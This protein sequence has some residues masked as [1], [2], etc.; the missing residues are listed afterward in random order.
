MSGFDFDRTTDRRHTGSVKWDSFEKGDDILPMWVADMD[1]ETAPAVKEA[2]M[3]RAATGIYGYT[4]IPM[5]EYSAAVGDWMERRHG[6]RPDPALTVI[7]T[8]VVPAISACIK[9]MTHPGDGVIVQTPV[10]N[11]FFS[12]IRNN[13]CRMVDAPLRKVDLRDMGLFTY[14]M[15]FN[16][17]ER[18]AADP[19][20]KVLL[21]CNPHN[22]AGRAWTRDELLKVAEICRRHEVTVVSDEIHCDLTMPGYEF[23]SYATLP[24]EFSSRAFVLASPS[25]AFNTAGLQIANIFAGNGRLRLAADRAVNDME[26][27]D[28]N[29][30]GVAGLIAAYTKGEEWLRELL[31]YLDGNYRALREFFRRELPGLSISRLEAT[32][33]VWVD[34]KPLGIESDRL[35]HLLL[36]EG[37][38]WL[39]SGVMYGADGFMR[40]N[41]ATQRARMMEGLRRFAGV[42]KDLI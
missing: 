3:A 11:C 16:A 4:H 24:E 27:C 32:Y 12:S 35:E 36:T 21:L 33:L 25:K 9:A 30:F 15:D 39:N 14:E 22:P 26:V 8:A 2:V 5:E 29:P 31:I 40:I 1:F 37:R 18:A 13:G 20:N 41:I 34:T 19:R 10:Y 23:V 28:V 6:Y 7:T 17:L 42:V 38:V